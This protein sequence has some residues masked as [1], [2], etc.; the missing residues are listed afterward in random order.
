MD[1]FRQEVLS[2]LLAEKLAGRGL[3]ALP[4]IRIDLKAPDVLVRFSGLLLA[5]EGEVGDQLGAEQTAW[6]KARERVE[7]GLADFALAL[8]YPPDLRTLPSL[9]DVRTAL[10]KATLRFCLCPP[11]EARWQE[12]TI[13]I[14]AAVLQRVHESL[15]AE[16]LVQQAV[17]FLREGME[18]LAQGILT[19]GVIPERIAV[20]LGIDPTQL[21][22]NAEERRLAVARI[23]AL[24]L[25]NALLFQ[26]ELA[27]VDHRVKTVRQCLQATNPQEE[28]SAVWQFILSDINYHA[29][30]DIARQ[31]LDT[32]PT[33]KR[34]DEALRACGQK[35]R[36]VVRLRVATRHDLMGRVY[37]RLLGDIAKPLGTYYTSV[38]AATLLLSFA[39][40]PER[41]QRSWHDL[42]EMARWRIADFACGTGTLLMAALQALRDHFLWATALTGS[43]QELPLIRKKLLQA[44][45]EKG[46]WGLDVLQSAVHLTA[47]TLALPLPEVTIK[48]MNL[49]ALDF[50][51]RDGEA[52]LGSLDL[53]KGS[54]FFTLA[55]RPVRLPRKGKGVTEPQPQKLVLPAEGFDLITM[56]PPFTR[57]TGGNL[58]FGSLPE[59]ER[60]QLQQALQRLLREE[61][62]SA[63]VTA[64]LGSVFLALADRYLKEGGRLAFVLPKALL[65]GVEWRVSRSLLV[66]DYLVE[67]IIVSHDPDQWNFSENTALSE[68]LLVAK[69]INPPQN[70]HPK[71]RSVNYTLPVE[72]DAPKE[73]PSWVPISE[74]TLCVNLWLNPRNAIEALL[75]AK[76]LEHLQSP[77]ASLWLGNEKVGEVTV[78]LWNEMRELP[79]WMLPVAFAQSSLNEVLIT[80]QRDHALRIGKEAQPLPLCPLRELGELGPQRRDIWDAFEPV[81]RPPG[82]PALWGIRAET[83]TTMFQ[84]PNAYLAPLTKARKGR[85]LR[86][87]Q[88]LWEGAGRLLIAERMRL[89]TQRLPAVVLPEPVLSNM[90][91]PL[92]L[93]QGV[94]TNAA[95]ILALWLN[96]T[97]GI[98][99]LIGNRVETEGPWVTFKKENLH[100]LPVLD[101]RRLTKRQKTAL[102][103]AFDRMKG[104]LLL[105]LSQLASDPV[106]REIDEAICK[107]LGLP[108]VSEVRQSLGQEPVLTLRPLRQRRL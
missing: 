84:Q 63:S 3:V 34:L 102:V 55:L 67:A 20:P 104:Q 52:R 11:M 16:D 78:R 23:G 39:L 69:K 97:L 7:N 19:V 9:D 92:R 37:H 56:N 47:T 38:A 80:L 85:P 57:S 96:S 105:P 81:D 60:R 4:E 45:L 28:L 88:R 2:V 74:A 68:V 106:R 51:M 44:L 108:D 61:K 89:N 83:M 46:L 17:L 62:V 95:E 99:L 77:T 40:A 18:V 59:K 64:G 53:L 30:F 87:A 103:A 91:W 58:L 21:A 86:D 54:A 35:V 94:D 72:P 8:V 100:A 13:D 24:I 5:I 73:E 79:H 50:G 14:L 65:S 75:I 70:P 6:R 26:E 22:K 49:Y 36:E 32:L 12:G 42:E 76:Q 66:N 15:V 107:V 43:R 27:R 25:A 41:W 90:W 82:Y 31:V 10:E 29:V 93:R 33:S 48:G 101:V 71:R 1:G 98:L